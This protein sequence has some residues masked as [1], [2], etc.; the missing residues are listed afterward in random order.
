MGQINKENLKGGKADNLSIK[1]IAKIHNVSPEA[2]EKEIEIGMEVEREHT[3]SKSK[4]KEIAK[5]HA[6]EDDKYY[7]DPK[8][9]LIAM[10]K[11]KEKLH[12]ES[13]RLMAL[14]GIQEGEKKFLTNEEFKEESKTSENKND[15]DN[16]IVIEFDQKDIEPGTDDDQLYKL[17]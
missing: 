10:E 6:V 15:N 12:E 8:T 17:G 7:T 9:G 14:A 16:F 11:K 3:N 4:Q 13:K 2:I 1:D 5:D